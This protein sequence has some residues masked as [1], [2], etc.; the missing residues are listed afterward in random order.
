MADGI[1]TY[2]DRTPVDATAAAKQH[3]AYVGA[4]AAAGWEIREVP[5]ADDLPDSAFVEDTV[6]VC[7]GLAVLTRPG[8]LERRAEVEGTEQA[9]RV[10]GLDVARIEEPGTLDGG[11]VLRVG[12]TLYVGRGGRTNAEGIC[13]LSELVAPLGFGV[14]PVPLHGVLHLKSAVTALPDGSVIAADPSLLDS[15]AFET[16]RIVP[17][18]AGSHVILLGDGT[19]LVAA[20]APRS[21]ELFDDWGFDVLVADIGEFEKMEGCVTCLSVLI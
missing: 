20:S 15:S 12:T 21:A 3:A 5:Q 11:D 8:A 10:L 2:G 6:V 7:G 1:V 19:C 17:E 4:I 16:M 18:E 9:V 13:Q 14:V